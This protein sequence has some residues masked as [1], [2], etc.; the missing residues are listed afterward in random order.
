MDKNTHGSM[1]SRR[2][3]VTSIQWGILGPYNRQIIWDSGIGGKLQSVHHIDNFDVAENIST[4]NPLWPETEIDHFIYQ[5]GPPMRPSKEV[6]TGKI[7]MNGRVWC[8]IDTLLSGAF[9]TISDAR[10]ETKRRLGDTV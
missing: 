2:T 4:V 10:N 6:K 7:F 1:S 3:S 8:A 9:D 5:L